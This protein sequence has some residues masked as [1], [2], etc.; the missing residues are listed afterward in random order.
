MDQPIIYHKDLESSGK[1]KEFTFAEQMANI[2]SEVSRAI[3]WTEKGKPDM[4]QKAFE[5]G[6]ELLDLTRRQ[7]HGPRLR[8]LGRAREVLCDYFAGNNDYASTPHDIQK[9]FD[10]FA[11]ACRR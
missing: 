1:W 11:Y 10:D 3:K 5:R 4:S 2:G 7:A 9:Y 8:E 6:L